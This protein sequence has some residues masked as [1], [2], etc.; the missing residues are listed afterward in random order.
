[1]TEIGITGLLAPLAAAIRAEAPEVSLEVQTLDL[2]VMVEALRTGR[3]DACICVPRLDDPNVLRRTLFQHDY[4]GICAPAHPRIGDRPSLSQFAAESQVVMTP[5]AGYEAVA[6]SL[7]DLGL[8][9]HI[10]YRLPTF[11]GVA[12]LVASSECVG[13]APMLA[14]QRVARSGQV[15]IFALPF[16][17]PATDVSLYTAEP[18]IQGPASS[19]FAE[20]IHRTLARP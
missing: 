2:D 16:E 8:E 14:A 15:R 5:Q 18:G 3:L 7:T 12:A 9:P 11:S 4:V 1:M 6:Q 20:V 17:P 19:W 10:A 13:F